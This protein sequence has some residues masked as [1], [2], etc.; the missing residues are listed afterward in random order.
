[1]TFPAKICLFPDMELLLGISAPTAASSCYRMFWPDFPGTVWAR[2]LCM[3]KGGGTVLQGKPRA[4]PVLG[5]HEGTATVR[6]WHWEDS[7]CNR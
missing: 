6:A 3:L 1:M 5:I 7:A 2:E 4:N